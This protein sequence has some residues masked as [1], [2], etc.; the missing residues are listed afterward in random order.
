MGTEKPI[1]GAGADQF[2]FLADSLLTESEGASLN[3]DDSAVQAG[4]EADGQK[5]EK[6]DRRKGDGLKDVPEDEGAKAPRSRAIPA[7]AR[8]KRRNVGS[9]GCNC[10]DPNARTGLSLACNKLFLE[11]TYEHGVR[12]RYGTSGHG[13]T[14]L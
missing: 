5:S 2:R 3:G 8:R 9:Q 6:A 1:L 14:R 11:L 12:Y 13:P 7:A 4:A 10:D